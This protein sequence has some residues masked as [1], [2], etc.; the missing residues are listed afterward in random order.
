MYFVITFHLVDLGEF[1]SR[2][3]LMS[4]SEV[5]TGAFTFGLHILFVHISAERKRARLTNK[6]LVY[7]KVYL[8]YFCLVKSLEFID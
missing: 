7:T 3:R 1:S 5:K 2:L 8:F 4:D 6:S